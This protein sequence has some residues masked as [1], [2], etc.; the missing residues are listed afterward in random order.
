MQVSNWYP[1]VELPFPQVAEQPVRW[2]KEGGLQRAKD[3]KAIVDL[4]TGKVFSIVSKDY[5]LIPHEEAI[6]KIEEV[7]H[8]NPAM[9]GYQVT[10]EF[11]NE[12]GRMRRKYR[13]PGITIQIREGDIVNMEFHLFNSYDLSWPFIVILG[14]YRLIC[15]NGLV[16]TRQLYRFKRRHVF[17][18]ERLRLD[19]ALESSIRQLQLEAQVWREWAEIPMTLAVYDRVMRSV[20]FGKNATEEIEDRIWNGRELEPDSAPLV[21]LWAFYNVLTWYITHRVVSLNRRVELENRL[22]MAIRNMG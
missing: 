20:E 6:E 3:H 22:R 13:F 9:V 18:L 7:I 19:R 4:R 16:V 15:T 10:T 11:Y 2:G 8:R 12:G 1:L 14:A 17:Q 5:R 21:T